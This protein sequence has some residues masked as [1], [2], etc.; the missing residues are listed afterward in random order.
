M[1]S[2][3]SFRGRFTCEAADVLASVLTPSHNHDTRTPAD[4]V[5][6]LSTPATV[7]VSTHLLVGTTFELAGSRRRRV[8]L[9]ASADIAAH[10]T[11]LAFRCP[12]RPGAMLRRLVVDVLTDERICILEAHCRW[13]GNCSWRTEVATV[14]KNYPG[15][16]Q[17]SN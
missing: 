15:G 12:W 6:C 14:L 3:L 2:P 4:I 9:P 11:I 10:F 5:P 7:P 13:S 1:Q 17:H 16:V 8:V